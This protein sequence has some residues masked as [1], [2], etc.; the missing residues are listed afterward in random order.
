METRHFVT[1]GHV[2]R[3]TLGPV[4][5]SLHLWLHMHG[6]VGNRPDVCVYTEL[7]NMNPPRRDLKRTRFPKDQSKRLPGW[8]AGVTYLRTRCKVYGKSRNSPR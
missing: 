8:F 7:I 4:L 5:T 3:T 1:T 2:I 6:H